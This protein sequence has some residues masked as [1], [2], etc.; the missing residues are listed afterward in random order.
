LIASLGSNG[1]YFKKD[2]KIVRRQYTTTNALRKPVY[3]ALLE[4]IKAKKNV[5][6]KELME[7]TDTIAV[8]IKN[9]NLEKG[10]SKR[11]FE[12]IP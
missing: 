7:D 1:N 3:N 12:E 8:T 10:L 9:Y 4:C 5:F 11:F 2:S 6:P